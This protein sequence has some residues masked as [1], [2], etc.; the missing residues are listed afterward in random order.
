MNRIETLFQSG[1]RDLLSIYFCA[2]TPR[3]DATAYTICALERHGVD[4]IEIGIPFSDPMADG[5]VIQRAATDALRHGMTLRRLF[6]DLTDIRCDV[7]LPL[8]LMGYLNPILRFGFEAFCARCAE[9]GIDGVIIPDLPFA[10][11]ITDYRP[12]AQR[13]GL[14]MIMLITPETSEER[15]R[16]IDAATDG[17][18]YMVSS[19]STTGARD[20]FDTPTLDYFRRIAALP[21]RNPRMIG[22]GV[23]NRATFSDACRHAS[24]AIIGSRFVSLL[25]EEGGDATRAIVRLKEAIGASADAGGLCRGRDV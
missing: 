24:G 17:F 18:L 8:I 13:Y 15:I 22:F 6:D 14:D 25:E 10:D 7:R 19:A 5:P 2:G 9:V 20:T 12:L 21:L 1:H 3:P 16:A 4:L 11:Y 23:S